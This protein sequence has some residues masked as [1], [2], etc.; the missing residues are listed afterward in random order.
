MNDAVGELLSL[1]NGYNYVGGNPINRRDPSG[2][3][4]VNSSASPDQQS[5]CSN[6]W[7][8]YTNIITDTYT[9]N[10]PR[11]VRILVT[12]EADYWANL[13]YSEFVSQWNSS[14]PPVG[15]DPGGAVWQSSLPILGGI[16]FAN[17][18]PGPEDLI[19]IGGLCIAGIW[20]LAAN[21]GAISLPL[22]QT[23]YFSES[24]ERT[25]EDDIAWP[26]PP[27]R[28]GA[29]VVL[30]RAIDPPELAFVRSVGFTNY[31]FSPNASG[32]YFALTLA[33]VTQFAGAD[34]NSNAVFT[35]T[36]IRVSPPIILLGF[37]FN[38]V[39]NQGAGW[40]IHFSDEALLALY[41]DLVASNER[42]VI[43]GA[44]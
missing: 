3:C 23:Y 31:G 44:V 20:A 29:K 13:P 40:S 5:Q 24:T 6:A 16:S 41:A 19:A 34:I 17:P 22:R 37:F 30:Y 12:Q 36:Q 39:G 15:T 26:I 8:Q 10:W 33:G 43:I 4:W 7:R 11:D 2:M 28:D 42:I 25:N 27:T 38:D 1:I 35:L 9:Q 14:R 18:A 32:K 21:A